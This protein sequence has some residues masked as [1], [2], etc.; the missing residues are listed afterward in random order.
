M[1]YPAICLLCYIIAA[2]IRTSSL[3]REFIPAIACALGAALSLTA[4][5]L[6]PQYLPTVHPLEAIFCGALSGLAATGSDQLWKK[7]KRLI[8]NK[9]GLDLD[10]LDSMLEREQRTNRS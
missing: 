8:F 6:C 4:L 3:K 9:Y 1:I 5:A 2:L 10:A 7:T